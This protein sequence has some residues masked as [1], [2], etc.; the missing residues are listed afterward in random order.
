MRAENFDMP[1]PLLTLKYQYLAKME[2]AAKSIEGEEFIV[3]ALVSPDIRTARVDDIQKV[4]HT[5]A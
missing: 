3:P 2:R 5:T 4:H 1:R